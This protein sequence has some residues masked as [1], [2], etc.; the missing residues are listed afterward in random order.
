MRV[1]SVP[2]KTIVLSRRIAILRMLTKKLNKLWN[3][4]IQVQ[5]IIKRENSRNYEIHKFI[6]KDKIEEEDQKEKNETFQKKIYWEGKVKR[7]K[8]TRV[9]WVL[10]RLPW[11]G[12]TSAL[13][14]NF[15]PDSRERCKAMQLCQLVVSWRGNCV[16]WYRKFQSLV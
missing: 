11:S 9:L 15:G 8:M 13:Q 4:K 16:N 1:W 6:F 3:P 5:K 14:G 2:Q 10:F 12:V 7:D